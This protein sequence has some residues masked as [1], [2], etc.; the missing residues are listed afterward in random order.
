[1]K[2]VFIQQVDRSARI[3]AMLFPLALTSATIV[4]L[5]C[6]T[7]IS[8]PGQSR[9]G[10]Q[11]IFESRTHG[12]RVQFRE[13]PDI[14]I[15]TLFTLHHRS[16]GLSAND[17]MRSVSTVHDR[18]GWTSH[19][20]HQYHRGILVEGAEYIL[21]EKNGVLKSGHGRVFSGLSCEITTAITKQQALTRALECVP[22]SRYMWEDIAMETW[23]RDAKNDP[24]FSYFPGPVLVITRDRRHLSNTSE[25]W[26]LAYKVSVMT[27]K[28]F[29]GSIVYLDATTG[30]EIERTP[31]L[32]G[33]TSATATT[34]YNGTQ[35]IY[36]KEVSSS[37]YVL[38]DDCQDTDIQTMRYGST[39]EE[40]GHTSTSW[41]THEQAAT[42][43][44]WA[45]KKT[46]EYFMNVH[47]RESF[48][49]SQGTMKQVFFGNESS[50]YAN[51]IVSIGGSSSTP[52]FTSLDII[53]H[54]WTHA[55]IDSDDGPQFALSDFAEY[56][57]LN[58]SYS[59]IFGS[60]VQCYVESS[61]SNTYELGE[62]IDPTKTAVWF[63]SVC[64]PTTY[65]D[66]DT[67]AGMNFNHGKPH[68]PK[69][70]NAGIN[71]KWFCLLANGGSGTNTHACSTVTYNLEGIG[72]EKA[73]AICFHALTHV[74]HLSSTS[75]FL[76]ARE[77]TIEALEHLIDDQ[78]TIYS[79][80][81]LTKLV[82]AW[83]AVGVYADHRA[84]RERVL[85]DLDV[86]NAITDQQGYP[87]YRAFNQIRAGDI[88]E[89]SPHHTRVQSTATTA[90]KSGKTIY[91]R[92]GFSAE[93]GCNYLAQI[94]PPCDDEFFE[95]IVA[96]GDRSSDG[97]VS[98]ENVVQ[99]FDDAATLYVGSNP[100]LDVA[101][102]YFSLHE[103]T[104]V[105]VDLV[106]GMGNALMTLVS[107]ETRGLGT[108][109]VTLDARHLASGIYH[110]VLRTSRAFVT[111]S[112]VVL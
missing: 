69:Y 35:T 38:H 76:D 14:N 50:S 2:R 61:C 4:T 71:N 41:S 84:V 5:H 89:E 22:A 91:L 52:W 45:A 93:A 30:Q 42:S 104:R 21:R 86:C 62:E 83:N 49:G 56:A 36:T 106:D 18:S 66:A 95:S 10:S 111:Y 107:N 68:L 40:I 87:V 37:Q 94:V 96:P 19:R 67:Y 34:Q 82:A 32:H 78:P 63:R 100:V 16:F 102:V 39:Y 53:G 72:R 3:P 90:F 12:G 17:E 11:S 7:V 79:S 59:D 13:R 108:H 26:V 28:P 43:A 31:A 75:D 99:D 70:T 46:Y 24:T 47:T 73:A 51:D 80:A 92:P 25:A 57:S 58:E 85:Y 9:P 33:C 6:L 81:D 48:D 65:G 55:L 103:P 54:E 64:S 27:L 60:M 98:T 101:I 88:C 97:P 112:I 15:G 23:L 105:S 77:G 8:L 29:G 20:F 74:N 109:R 1:M 110:C 44:H